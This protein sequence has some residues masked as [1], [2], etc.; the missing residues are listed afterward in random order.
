MLENTLYRL[1]RE[2]RLRI[3][4]FGGSITEGG[5]ENAFR[6]ALKRQL[7]R[8]FPSAD[9]HNI[10]AAIGGTGSDLGVYR[11]DRDL[12]CQAPDL[13]FI[14]FAV[15]DGYIPYRETL[16]NMEGIV[17]AIRAAR[18][19]ADMVMLYTTTKELA[20]HL[21]RGQVY[22]A[23]AAHGAVAFHYDLP[24]LDIGEALRAAIAEA[25]GEWLR[26]TRD[27]V[28]PN[29]EGYAVYNDCIAYW[30]KE[31]LAKPAPD[32]LCAH[33]MPAPLTPRCRKNARLL[34]A[35]AVADG[36]PGWRP[37]E[38]SM[39]RRYDRYVQAEMPGAEL[40]FEFDGADI[41]VYW[42]KAPDAGM[43]EYAIDGGPWRTVNAWDRYCLESSRANY[44][45]LAT[46]LADGRHRVRL[47]VA[48][49]K[50]AQSAGAAIRIG[51]FMISGQEE[52]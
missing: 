8:R 33:A 24:Q 18:P 50:D 28:H 5:G 20:G 30:M 42:M 10:Q 6:A 21:P 52:P 27:T 16:K 43:L 37:V 4:W 48:E 49:E 40:T 26:Y 46:N 45:F 44:A 3:C 11:L 7:C 36:V 19:E 14:E 35:C 12:L 29:A 41:G 9:I 51:A 1:E 25:E 2:G 32:A 23:R 13:V 34:D 15:N 22:T 39:C 38:E 47:R 31:V 17:R